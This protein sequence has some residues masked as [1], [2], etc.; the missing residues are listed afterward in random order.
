MTA[1][2]SV[3]PGDP[4][5]V[6]TAVRALVAEGSGI[7]STAVIPGN[8]PYPAPQHMYATV[9]LISSW[10]DGGAFESAPFD[11]QGRAHALLNV[12]SRYSV[13][14][15]RAGAL[16]AAFRFR[17]WAETQDG[18]DSMLRRGLLYVSSGDVR[19]IDYVISSNFEERAGLDLTVRHVQRQVID[20]QP[21]E[22]VEF[23]VSAD[24]QGASEEASTDGP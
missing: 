4:A 17:I 5:A 3:I 21:T 9:L 14:W 6:A 22:S 8:D 13:Q 19:Q 20:R 1:V 15:Y 12:A 10:T 11:D 18:A 2:G 23:A 16:Q 7:S 24:P